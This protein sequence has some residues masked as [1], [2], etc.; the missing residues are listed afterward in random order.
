ML[1]IAIFAAVKKMLLK[2]F[3]FIMLTAF[4]VETISSLWIRDDSAVVMTDKD[5]KEESKK[6]ESGKEDAKDK[7]FKQTASF[8]SNGYKRTLFVLS[9]IYF[10]YSAYLSLPEIP[11]EQA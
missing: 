8:Q 2:I 7:L 9:L 3:A 6:S 4:S 11:P 1:P 10:K 5:D